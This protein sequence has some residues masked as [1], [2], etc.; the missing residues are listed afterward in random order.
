MWGVYHMVTNGTNVIKTYFYFPW[1]DLVFKTL[2][3]FVPFF[4]KNNYICKFNTYC[5]AMFLKIQ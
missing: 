2:F 1:Y 4:V 3:Y 5:V